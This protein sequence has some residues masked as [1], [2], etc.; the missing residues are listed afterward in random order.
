MSNVTAERLR[1]ILNYDPL[2]GLFRWKVRLSNRIRI[3]DVAGCPGDRGYISIG[4]LGE[5]HR[6]Q[7]LAVLYM[8]G[9]WPEFEVDHENGCTSDNRWRNLRDV[10][11]VV[12]TQNMRAAKSNS[13]SG[14]LG[15]HFVPASGKWGARIKVDGHYRSLGRHPTKDAAHGAYLTAKRKAHA[16]NTL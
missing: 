6:G 14:L 3:G 15:V 1:E 5:R 2:T 13:R 10:P 9:K 11:H 4:L 16:G 7:R 8:T 12:N